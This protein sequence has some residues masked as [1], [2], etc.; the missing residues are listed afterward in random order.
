MPKKIVFSLIYR[1]N[2]VL[3]IRDY[4]LTIA[5]KIKKIC[6]LTTQ[7]ITK[8]WGYDRIFWDE[9]SKQN[10]WLI[11][12]TKWAKYF[13]WTPHLS[14]FY[15]K[16]TSKGREKSGAILMNFFYGTWW[17]N[18]IYLSQKYLGISLLNN[19]WDLFLVKFCFVWNYTIF[20]FA[21]IIHFAY[22]LK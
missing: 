5:E 18:L 11:Y 22:I 20:E 14:K 21:T 17:L 16:T 10:I 19:V 15:R 13:V 2:H 9:G 4:L 7:K 1:P 12:F 3:F 8:R 6:F